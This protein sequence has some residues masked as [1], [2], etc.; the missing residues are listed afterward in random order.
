MNVVKVINDNTIIIPI[1]EKNVGY[2][3]KING[4]ENGVD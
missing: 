2:L 1:T 3:G 4:K